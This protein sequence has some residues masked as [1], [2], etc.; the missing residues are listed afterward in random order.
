MR[1]VISLSVATVIVMAVAPKEAAA[2]STLGSERQDLNKLRGDVWSAWTAVAHPDRRSVIPTVAIL[3]AVVGVVPHDSAI[4]A[5]MTRHEGAPLMR[6]IG[7]FREHRTVPLEGFGSG[8]YLLPL[9]ALAYGAG[10]LSHSV[11]VRDAGL[12]CAA[13]HL[14][15]AG[16]REVIY[17]TVSRARPNV[18]SEAAPFSVPGK[19][20][21]NS[22]S[23]L[24]GHIANSTACASFMAHRYQ[25]GAP[26]LL[27][28]A[29]SSGIGLG[30]MADGWHWASDTMAGAAL[31]YVIGKFIADRQLSRSSV[32][33]NT[34]S[35][36]DARPLS[37]TWRFTF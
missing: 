11:A 33:S 20:E 17:R 3:T 36:T 21:W 22:H 28:Y 6:L 1:S 25:I 37:F 4:F 23:F 24:S 32:D 34:P 12:G 8:Q 31:G 30:R 13:S 9:S 5:W 16:L 27:M 29:Y 18:A 19:R 7:P 2:Q 10:R 26:A 35:A 14:S 15:S